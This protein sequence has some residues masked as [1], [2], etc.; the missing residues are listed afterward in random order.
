M[1]FC[2]FSLLFLRKFVSDQQES[3]DRKSNEIVEDI[4]ND[5]S[6]F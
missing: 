2:C 4:F 5:S 6:N 3:N 1:V